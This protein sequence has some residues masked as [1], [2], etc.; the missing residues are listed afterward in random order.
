LSSSAATPSANK[1]VSAAS[2]RNAIRQPAQSARMPVIS[3]PKNP[4]KL[5][6]DV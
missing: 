4:P 6:A 1:S 5:A 3:R 2:A